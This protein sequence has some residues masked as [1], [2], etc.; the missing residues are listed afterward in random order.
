MWDCY[1]RPQLRR[2]EWQNLNGTWKVNGVMQEVPAARTEE[3]LFYE[4]SFDF[5]R[6]KAR[7]L[8]HFGA[9]DQTARV[10]LNG[11]YLGEH[12]GGYLPFNFE[13]TDAVAEGTNVLQVEVTDT[14][15]HTYP[16]G[17]QTKKPGGMWYTPVSGIWQTVWIE[18]VPESYIQ[19]VRITPDLQGVSLEIQV[20]SGEETYI[21]K[22]RVEP[23]HP[24]SWTPEHPKLYTYTV[25]EGEDACEIYY[26]LRTIDIREIN[27][28]RRVCL[29]GQPIFLHGVLDQGYFDPGRFLPASPKAYVQDIRELKALGFN[30]LRKH[31]KLEPEVFYAACDRLGILVMQ[32]MVNSG[33]YRFFRD[34][35]LGTLGFHW[36]DIKTDT[37]ERMSFFI[38][39]CEESLAALYN[40]P[41]VCLYTIF[42]EGWGQF[43]SDMLYTLLKTQDPTRLYDAASGW[44]QQKKSDFDSLHIYFRLKRL[45]PKIRP[46]L[47]SECGGY[48]LN[49]RGSKKTYGYGAAK[50]QEELTKKIVN[51]YENMVIPAVKKG[52]CGCI[53]TQLSD[54]EEEI[55]GLFT[56]DRKDCKVIPEQLLRISEK[57]RAELNTAVSSNSVRRCKT[58]SIRRKAS[59]GGE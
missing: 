42:N 23:S 18:Q 8:L 5:H 36:K 24:Q 57:L 9:A 14:L 40:H 31:I 32:D 58:G 50:D 17:K 55:N 16:Y 30:L 3:Q 4:R 19:S 21:R 45:K 59:G 26:A 6:E 47:L 11:Q 33:D 41:S 35:L 52:L 34:T 53:Y 43:N 29:N 48:T 39:H 28:I 12:L 44:F 15:N 2:K 13:I 27:G 25:T 51:L 56:Y 7:V 37:D 10:T 49:L 46:M 38:S 1:P 54:I 20:K 22:E